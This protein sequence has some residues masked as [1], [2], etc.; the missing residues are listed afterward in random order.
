MEVVVQ[1][2]GIISIVPILNLEVKVYVYFYCAANID[3]YLCYLTDGT[4]QS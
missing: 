2:S 4:T 1:D 3:I